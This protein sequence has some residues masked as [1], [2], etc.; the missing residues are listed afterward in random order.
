MFFAVASLFGW[1][2]I[3]GQSVNPVTCELI[4]P[5][6]GQVVSGMLELQVKASSSAAPI[7]RVEI[8]RDV[9]LVKIIYPPMPPQLYIAQRQ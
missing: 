6:N 3:R 7:Q 9:V 4:Q 2:V 5:T 1:C 8:Y